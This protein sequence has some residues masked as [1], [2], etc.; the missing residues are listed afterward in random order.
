MPP[1]PTLPIDARLDELLALV[2]KDGGAVLVAEPGAGKTTRVPA[3]LL[4]SRGRSATDGEVW[5]VEPRRL[6][7]RMAAVRVAE[8]LGTPVGGEVGYTVRFEDRTSCALV[9]P[10][11]WRSGSGVESFLEEPDAN[12]LR[13]ADFLQRSRSPGPTLHH[14]G[15]QCK[16]N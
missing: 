3:A 16:P 11:L 8:E 4:R 15:E 12:A 10:V 6:A 7:A 9:V 1:R 14:L 2:A 13:A 5:V